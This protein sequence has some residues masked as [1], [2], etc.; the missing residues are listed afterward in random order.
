MSRDD[1]F[2]FKVLKI[3]TVLFERALIVYTIF[4][5]SFVNKI[6]KKV[7]SCCYEIQYLYINCEIASS[8]PFLIL[9]MKRL[10]G[11]RLWS[12]ISYRKPPIEHVQFRR[13]P[14]QLRVET[15]ENRPT[16]AK[17]AGTEITMRFWEQF[18]E[19]VCVFTFQR[20]KQKHIFLLNKAGYKFKNHLCLYRP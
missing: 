13:F 6:Q 16:T 2:F 1:Y 14:I 8:N 17:E 18:L 4:C 15:G 19:L 3:K 7:S 12:E 5:W 9:S 20:S 10:T 11:T